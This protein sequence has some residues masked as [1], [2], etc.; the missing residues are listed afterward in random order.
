MNK[1]KET[2]EKIKNEYD[3]YY[4]ENKYG[5]GTH[6]NEF[7][8]LENKLTKDLD[9]K[10]LGWIKN[11]YDCYYKDELDEGSPFAYLEKRLIEVEEEVK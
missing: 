8:L 2:L 9:K 6:K 1:Y 4:F 3:A 7:E 10:A 5:D 11:C